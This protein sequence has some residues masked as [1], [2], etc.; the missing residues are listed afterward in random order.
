MEKYKV[1]LGVVI[2]LVLTIVVHYLLLSKIAMHPTL[3]ALI[4]II[5]FFII[6]LITFKVVM[7]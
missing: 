3:H 6:G 4:G 1:G 2:S 5:I 7:K